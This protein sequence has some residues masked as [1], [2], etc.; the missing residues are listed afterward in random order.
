MAMKHKLLLQ[1]EVAQRLGCSTTT[2]KR[3]RLSGELPYIPGRPVKIDEKDLDAYL[4]SA[5]RQRSQAAKGRQVEPTGA[6]STAESSATRALRI[7]MARQ[8]REQMK[9]AEQASSKERK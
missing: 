4:E 9:A 8:V 5:H 6:R 7:W 2:V 3:L 1:S